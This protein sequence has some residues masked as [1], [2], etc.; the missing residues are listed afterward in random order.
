MVGRTDIDGVVR[1]IE[2]EGTS[3]GP[4][5]KP[6]IIAEVGIN[7]RDD[8]TLAKRFIELAAD[9]G[10]D[11]VKFQTHLADAE[12]AEDEIRELGA[13]DVYD[14]VSECEWTVEEHETL[15]AHADESGVTFL[16]TPFSVEGVEI[17]ETL[18]VPAIK[19]GSGE[20]TNQELLARAG[21]TGNPLLVS[22][23]MHTRDEIE[24]AC[25]FLESVADDFALFYCVSEY[26]TSAADFDFGTIDVLQQLADV[27]V[28]FSDHSVGVEAAKVAIGNGATII[29]KH[30]TIDR[31]L[32]GPDQAVSIEPSTLEELC[33]F[34]ELY[35]ETASEKDGLQG[36]ESDIKTWARH[37]LVT[38]KPIAAGEE[39]TEENLTTKRPGTGISANKFFDVL[40]RRAA[41]EV[42]GNSF[43]TP[44][45]VE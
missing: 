20:L 38:K 34:A 22:T 26:P 45:D 9:A 23:G 7:A 43:L 24:E 30:F 18:N 1:M 4:G 31:R 41:Q 29:E 10:A 13:D 6:Y 12:M 27:P 28:G 14:T 17:L 40:G 5:E 19:I 11:A 2:I 35:Y 37:S 25:S 15:Q 21:E 36:E 39:F 33:S 16:S 8:I 44:D 32:P 3:I 42:P